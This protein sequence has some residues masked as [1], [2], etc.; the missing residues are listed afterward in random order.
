MRLLLLGWLVLCLSALSL[1]TSFDYANKGSIGVGTAILTGSATAGGSLT[2]TSPLVSTNSVSA[3]GTVIIQ[4]GTLVATSNPDVFDFTGGSLMVASNGTTLFQGTFSSATVTVMGSS[5]FSINGKLNNGTV[6]LTELD[7]HGDVDGN[8]W[9]VTP[10]PATLSLLGT[11]VGLIGIAFFVR[12]RKPSDL[13]PTE[14]LT[15]L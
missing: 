6:L 11:G 2:L 5:T 15:N 3:Q 8:T 4:T 9:V 1:A 7:K 10:E 13:R 12:R 14:H